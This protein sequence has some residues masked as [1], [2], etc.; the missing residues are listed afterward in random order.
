[1]CDVFAAMTAGSWYCGSLRSP[2]V[3]YGEALIAAVYNAVRGG[4]RWKQTLL[5]ITYDEH[6]GC[7][8]HVVPPPARQKLLSIRK[9]LAE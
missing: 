9:Q 1:M 6:G 4:P 3:A 5:V 7:F 2:N 8:D